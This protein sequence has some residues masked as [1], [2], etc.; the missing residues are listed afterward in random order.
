MPKILIELSKNISNYILQMFGNDYLKKYLEYIKSEPQFYIRF[1]P[2]DSHQMLLNN[3]LQYGIKLEKVPNIQNAFRIEQGKDK[4]GKTVE[5]TLGK[6]YI[7]SLSSMIP[8]LVL[9]PS[10]NDIVLDLCAA[11]GSKSTQIS[12]LMNNKGTLYTNEISVQR[13]R[14]LVHNL[15]KINALNVGVIQYKG[16]LLS[17][18]YENYFDKILVDAPCSAL[19]IIQKKGEVNNWWN[20][21]HVNRISDTQLRLLIS[22]IKMLKIGGELV[23]STCTLTIEENELILNKVL[24][25]YPVEIIDF[26]IPLKFNEGFIQFG[27]EKLN[28]QIGKSKRIV[29]WEVNSEGFFI[30]KLRKT[31]ETEP[32][33]KE[34][35]KKDGKKFLNFSD[36]NISKYLKQI[37]AHFGIA[38]ETFNAYKYILK[39]K[40]IY[41]INNNWQAEKLEIFNRI[42]M[43]FGKIDNRDNIHFHTHAV[44]LLFS[45]ANKNIITLDNLNML[46]TYFSGG[47]IK[48]LTTTPGQ[49][50]IKYKNYVLGSAVAFD[51]GIKSQFPR[52]LRTNNIIYPSQ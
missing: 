45:F 24:K 47:I 41:F 31:G 46:Q 44:Q 23:Y 4:V 14:S 8:A 52:A 16:E 1:N 25:K 27:S 42:G 32:T 2:F 29:P 6:Y 9:A 30:A 37:E 11:P 10:E 12:E 22:A 18:I 20:N 26:D 34:K 36:K 33:K 5:F 39:G 13:L 50:I 38:F 28:L 43:K 21:K 40:D 7:Q 35:T 48:G 51:G 3:L 15:D 49:K 19:G 17:K